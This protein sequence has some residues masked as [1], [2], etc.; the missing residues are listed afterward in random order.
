MVLAVFRAKSSLTSAGTL[1]PGKDMRGNGCAKR[2]HA[3][4]RHAEASFRPLVD[5]QYLAELV[6]LAFRISVCSAGGVA[7]KTRASEAHRLNISPLAAFRIACPCS[8]QEMKNT[9]AY[10]SMRD[11][12]V[13]QMKRAARLR[14][15]KLIMVA[16]PVRRGCI[17]RPSES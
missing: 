11:S 5:I 6:L 14:F 2:S 13:K 16:R 7:S 17:H 4:S 15:H 10:D 3:S 12:S 9:I 1:W 8:S